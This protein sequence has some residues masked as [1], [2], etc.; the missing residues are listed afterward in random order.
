WTNA[1]TVGTAWNLSGNSGTTPGTQFM[2]TTDNQP[3]EIKVNGQRALRLDPD[4]TGRGAPNVIGGSP[5]NYVSPGVFGATI[6]GGGS[7]NYFGATFLTN[8]VSANFGTIAGGGEN[9]S[10]GLFSSIGGGLD[11]IGSG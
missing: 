8:V 6:G 1:S 7:L 10:G 4:P 2:G 9:T 5:Q 11:N 3:V